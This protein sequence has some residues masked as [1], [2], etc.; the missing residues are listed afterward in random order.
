MPWVLWG[1]LSCRRADDTQA[2][3]TSTVLVPVLSE[4]LELCNKQ[5]KVHNAYTERVTKRGG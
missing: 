4:I 1:P 5:T 2:N 3:G